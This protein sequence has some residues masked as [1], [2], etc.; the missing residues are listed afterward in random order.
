MKWDV[1]HRTSC[2]IWA[3]AFIHGGGSLRAEGLAFAQSMPRRIYHSSRHKSGRQVGP[4]VPA[5]GAGG[6]AGR[7]AGE[8]EGITETKEVAC[9]SVTGAPADGERNIECWCWCRCCLLLAA[10]GRSEPAAHTE[11]SCCRGIHWLSSSFDLPYIGAAA[12]RSGCHGCATTGST[13]QPGSTS[14][15][16]CSQAAPAAVLL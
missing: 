14:Q 6:P 1:K 4:V 11:R 5:G 2:N 7:P 10:G 16:G 13:L 8:K 9:V 15:P 12:A 3:Q